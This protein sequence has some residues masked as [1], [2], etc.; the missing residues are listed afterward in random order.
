MEDFENDLELQIIEMNKIKKWFRNN[1]I[2]K[3][4]DNNNNQY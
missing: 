1:R 3:E 2:N 4:N